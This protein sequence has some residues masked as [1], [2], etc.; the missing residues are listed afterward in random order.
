MLRERRSL[1]TEFSQSFERASCSGVESSTGKTKERDEQEC[2]KK[3]DLQ[4]L[5]GAS[6]LGFVSLVVMQWAVYVLSTHMLRL[7]A[8]NT[9]EPGRNLGLRDIYLLGHGFAVSRE[10]GIGIVL[11]TRP[12]VTGFH[13]RYSL[14][15]IVQKCW[16]FLYI[17]TGVLPKY[18]LPSS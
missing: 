14:L 15:I 2:V 5:H 17:C 8:E 13:V 4:Y 6:K 18:L 7:W 10:H 1:S 16:T 12:T 9:H 11:S 3:V